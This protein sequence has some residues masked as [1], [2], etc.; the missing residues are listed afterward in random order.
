MIDHSNGGVIGARLYLKRDG[1]RYA[2][3]KLDA[4]KPMSLAMTSDA[5][6]KMVLRAIAGYD[7]K[8]DY[9][10]DTLV[11]VLV[12]DSIE[13]PCGEYFITTS[14]FNSDGI[15]SW[16]DITGF[17]LCYKAKRVKIEERVYF[18]SGTLY[19]M[20]IEQML[21]L[22]GISSYIVNPSELTMATD[23]EDWD[24]GTDRLTIINQLL[25]E[26][27]YN[28]LYMGMDG[29]IRATKHN[30]PVGENVTIHYGGNGARILVPGSRIEIDAFDHYNIFN[31]T[32]ENPDLPMYLTATAENNHAQN[33]FSTINQGRVPV[34]R[35]VDNVA[36]QETLQ[37]MADRE[38]QESM[39]AY[40]SIE[41]ETGVNPQ[42]SVFDIV[43]INKKEYV[44][45]VSE[46][47]WNMDFS[48]GGIMS[49]R[50][51]KAVLTV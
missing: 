3:M 24:L 25:K 47:S 5:E 36:D 40:D 39:V 22:S 48:V 17:D 20:A 26:I 42:H 10:R 8:I 16:F 12:F 51:K 32:C 33:P 23:R 30:N 37:A 18:P 31:Y 46:I 19:T 43:S 45:I 11:P 27:N 35:K 6:I 34:W 41:F 15:N 13:Y 38:C 7:G 49:H 28:T 4:N 14:I 44:G 2:Q 29:V 9:Y 50:G 21:T 1:V